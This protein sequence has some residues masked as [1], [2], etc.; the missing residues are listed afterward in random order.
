MEKLARSKELRDRL[1]K[2]AQVYADSYLD[3][4]K[5]AENYIAGYRQLI[6]F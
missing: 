3:P 2:E 1:G 4:F 6:G 5:T